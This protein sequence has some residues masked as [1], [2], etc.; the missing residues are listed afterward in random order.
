MDLWIV[1]VPGTPRRVGLRAGAAAVSPD[2]ERL[3][4]FRGTSLCL[5]RLD[6]S[7]L[8]E[9]LSVRPAPIGFA[10]RPMGG[11]CASTRMARTAGSVGSG[12]FR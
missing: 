9:L 5:A 3:A 4:F 8:R 6:G 10:G 7:E 11:A 12:R 2:G 1:P